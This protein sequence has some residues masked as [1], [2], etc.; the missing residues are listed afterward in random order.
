MQTPYSLIGI[1]ATLALVSASLVCANWLLDGQLK[2]EARG[3]Q[4][5]PFSPRDARPRPPVLDEVWQ[6]KDQGTGKAADD[7]VHQNGS[8]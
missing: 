3:Q 7:G 6:I 5:P 2:R 4:Y 1:L 8:D